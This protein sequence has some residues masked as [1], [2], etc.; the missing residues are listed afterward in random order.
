MSPVPKLY[1]NF[2]TFIPTR[3]WSFLRDQDVLFAVTTLSLQVMQHNWK[4]NN[5][6]TDWWKDENHLKDVDGLVILFIF[7]IHSCFLYKWTPT[8]CRPSIIIFILPWI[9]KLCIVTT[10]VR[11]I[12][13]ACAYY[14]CNYSPNKKYLCITRELHPF[15]FFFQTNKHIMDLIKKNQLASV[16]LIPVIVNL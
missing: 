8:K 6:F 9:H 10:G 1:K 5:Q 14:I 12:L 3:T 13:N 15:S 11:T 7:R 2:I 16:R 4:E